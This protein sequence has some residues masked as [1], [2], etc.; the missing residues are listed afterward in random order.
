MKKALRD[1]IV[2][3]GDHVYLVSGSN[4]NWVIVKDGDSATLIDSGYPA[5]YE[6]LL[7]SL[8]AVGLAADAVSALLVTHAHND[9]IGGAERLHASLDIPVLMHTE[10]VPHAR[11]E[12][13]HQVS[14]GQVLKEAWR[15]GVLPW[16]LHAVRAG[17]TYHVPVSEPDSFPITGPLDLPGS[18]TPVHTPGHT[19]GHCAYYLPDMGILISGDALITAHPTSRATGPQL[20]PDMFHADRAKALASLNTLEEIDAEVILPGHGPV[21]RGSVKEAVELARRHAD[22]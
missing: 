4:T 16:A 14:V 2:R 1:D 11:R 3:V 10:E 5:D 8:S 20:L 12:F 9:H 7:A 15:P 17:G 19:R 22:R 18:P 21:Y 13:L 6:Q